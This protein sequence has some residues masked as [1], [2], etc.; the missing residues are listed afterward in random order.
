MK[1]EADNINL[2]YSFICE[3]LLDYPEYI[4]SPRGL[5][6][7]EILTAKLVLR[8]P[9]N[10]IITLPSR[11]FSKRYFVGELAFYL[12]GSNDLDFIAH[13]AP[14]WRQVSDDDKTV[15]SAYGKRLFRNFNSSGYTQFDYAIKCLKE[16]KDSRKSIMEIYN[17]NDARKSKDNPCTMYLQFFIRNDK[18]IAE[19]HMRSNDIWLGIP[20]DI[21][22]FTI[23]QE[24]IFVGL[25]RHY[26]DLE[27][28]PYKHLVGSLHLYER[29]FND[30]KMLLQDSTIQESSVLPKWTME[31]YKQL[32]NFLE[33]ERK[34]RMDKFPLPDRL[35]AIDPFIH[36][37]I[38]WL[39]V[40]K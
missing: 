32:D 22:F 28:G 5:K 8:N 13:Y 12:D 7:H 19:A 39:E 33:Y 6:V 9:R 26:P 21:A 1:F 30:V 4:V 16:D 24:M 15:N 14:F 10:R 31:T 37:L 25:K 35:W 20:Y 27:L 3:Q 23:V 40:K 2:L 17:P 38:E 34:Y 18:L 36:K 29:N 11:K